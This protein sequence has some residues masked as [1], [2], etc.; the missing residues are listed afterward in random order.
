MISGLLGWWLLKVGLFRISWYPAD[1]LLASHVWLGLGMTLA[2]AAGSA[3]AVNIID[4]AHG[5]SGFFIVA[6]C[7]ALALIAHLA[8]DGFVFGAALVCAASVAGFLLWNFPRGQIFLGDA[9]A[10]M[11]GFLIAQLGMMLITRRPEVSPWSVMLIMAYPAWETLFSMYRRAKG[12]LRRMG[13]PDARHLHQL[14]YRRILK[15]APR[16]ADRRVRDFR[17]ATTAV[18]IWPLILL[19][20]VPAVL[21]WNR[22]VVLFWLSWLFAATYVVLYMTIVR[23]KVPRAVS[24]RIA[25][26][27]QSCE[28]HLGAA[29]QVQN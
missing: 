3:H 13:Q 25:G 16:S 20:M 21:F 1:L 26:L 11:M 6:A 27:K 23:F 19:C 18:L 10:Y 7:T 24:G 22:T 4:G 8:G 17:S 5:L 12:G 15:W 14:I 9:G 28:E 29:Q 2:A